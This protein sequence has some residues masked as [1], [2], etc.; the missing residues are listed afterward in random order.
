MEKR[1]LKVFAGRLRSLIDKGVRQRLACTN[2]LSERLQQRI[3]QEGRETIIELATYTWFNRIIALCYMETHGILPIDSLAQGCELQILNCGSGR[4]PDILDPERILEANLN[5]DYVSL[6][7]LT[8]E[9]QYEQVLLAIVG[10]VGESIP[11]VFG[12]VTAEID[13]LIPCGFLAKDGIVETVSAL[14]GG[15]FSQVESLGWLYQYY[16]ELNKTKDPLLSTQVFTPDWVV[17][18][19]VDNSLQVQLDSIDGAG[20]KS[21]K[22]KLESIRFLDPCS[23]SGHVLVYAF[24]IFYQ[25]YLDQGYEPSIIAELI[26]T[27]N[28]YG[29]EID[30]RAA[31]ISALLCMMTARKYDSG[32]FRR[33]ITLNI[34]AVQQSNRIWFKNFQPQGEAGEILEYLLTIFK[35]ARE[36]GTLIRV[37][38]RNYDKLRAAIQALPPRQ[39]R[40]T[41]QRLEP[42]IRQAE[43]L[44]LPYDVVVTNPPYLHRYTSKLRSFL[45]DNYAAEKSDLAIAFMRRGIDFLKPNGKLGMITMDAWMFQKAAE[46]F[47]EEMLQKCSVTKMLHLGYGVFSGAMVST[48]AFVLQRTS[49]KRGLFVRAT[50]MKLGQKVKIAEQLGRI[51]EAGCLLEDDTVK[52]YE[53]ESGE[54]LALPG[55]VLAFTLPGEMRALLR[56]A[57]KL[58]D[59]ATIKQGL[60]TA[61]NERFLRFWWEVDYE[62][63]KF[64]AKNNTEAINSGKK[65]FP[66]NK[67]GVSRKWYGNNLYVIDW[68]EDGTAVRE[69]PKALIRGE[70]YFFRPALTW[71]AVTNDKISFRFVPQGGTFNAAGPEILVDDENLD[72]YILGLLN[73]RAMAALTESLTIGWNK[74]IGAVANL[75][76]VLD[77]RYQAELVNLVRECIRLT[78]EEWDESEISYDFDRHPLCKFGA[79]KVE[80]AA[81]LWRQKKESRRDAINR[82]EQE[83][84]ILAEK[85]FQLSEVKTSETPRIKVKLSDAEMTRSLL[86]Y[87]VGWSFGRYVLAGGGVKNCT[88]KCRYLIVS[89]G[90]D[91]CDIVSW[92]KRFLI[93]AFDENDLQANLEWLAQALGCRME[94]SSEQRIRRYFREEF[95]KDHTKLYADPVRKNTK[96]PIYWQFSSGSEGVFQAICYAHQYQQRLIKELYEEHV[97]VLAKEVCQAANLEN[98]LNEQKRKGQEIKDF[99]RWLGELVQKRIRLNLDDGI[100]QNYQKVFGV[101]L[102]E[103]E[104]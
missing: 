94:E 7:Q 75:P 97:Q 4:K 44:A 28:L 45:Q 95:F 62:N 83:I 72:A 78:K 58:N 82:H 54:F 59:F 20:E 60:S 12:G 11:V 31:Q 104:R 93:E 65:W 92:L 43:I 73:S 79:S 37:Q 103:H 26:L 102:H 9:Q 13:E 48:V 38:N 49:S 76:I 87:F 81:E 47:R 19:L 69:S 55:K 67:G 53:A 40:R 98:A 86:S 84:D 29:L 2:E 61:D 17:K 100:L 16:N 34:L 5:L 57:S 56:R 64:R 23:G 66:H 22:T 39:A 74:S 41:C 51:K 42:L 99:E 32:I 15:V 96:R 46:K 14:G 30:D 24:K 68:A 35:D 3:Q 33:R 77:M 90:K 36:Y 50:E 70:K 71:S 8:T 52:I 85:I 91:D 63:I 6:E 101:D 80:M 27:K 25:K 89:P 10:K 88:G 18:F 21:K 1:T